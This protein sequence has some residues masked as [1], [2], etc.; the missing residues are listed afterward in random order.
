MAVPF[1][2]NEPN[3]TLLTNYTESYLM[4]V[5]GAEHCGN[6]IMMRRVEILANGS[7]LYISLT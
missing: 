6:K 5:N 3:L 4:C 2:S 1:V 7:D